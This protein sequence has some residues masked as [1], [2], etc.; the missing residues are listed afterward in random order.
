MRE[1]F[2]SKNLGLEERLDY[3]EFRQE[4]LFNDTEVD[5]MLFEYNI[6]REQYRAIMDLMD[7]YRKKIGEGN[8]VNHGSY[9]QSIY[10][11]VPH[12]DGDYHFCEYIAR[13]FMNAERWEEVFPALYGNLPKYK[14]LF[15]NGV[16]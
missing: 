12:L 6:S 7:D 10:R 8:D 9:E 4:L 15:E 1:Q 14:G 2:D 16:D 5:R 11:I 13:A 3:I